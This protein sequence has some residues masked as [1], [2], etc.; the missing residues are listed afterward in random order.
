[1]SSNSPN[2]NS[3]LITILQ[4]APELTLL[5]FNLISKIQSFSGE[6]A[7]DK[8]KRL[9]AELPANVQDYLA[10]KAE[11]AA[12]DTGDAPTGELP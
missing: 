8:V 5:I 2:V 12:V 11:I 3:P 1:M 10:K 9:T 4:D 7:A 6:T